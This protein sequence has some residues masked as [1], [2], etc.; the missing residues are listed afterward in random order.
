[1]FTLQQKT[2]L[3]FNDRV[4][5]LCKIENTR[6]FIAAKW[7]REETKQPLAIAHF[8]Y[9]EKSEIL[10]DMFFFEIDNVSTEDQGIY[11]CVAN[12]SGYGLVVAWYKLQVRGTEM[13]LQLDICPSRPC[14]RR[15]VG[16]YVQLANRA[17]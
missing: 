9:D 11:K 7:I 4:K 2:R 16:T 13:G 8:L 6:L 17:G 15:I 5:L 3:T 12:F 1:M 10:F 14:L